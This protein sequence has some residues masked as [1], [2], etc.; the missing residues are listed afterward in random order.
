MSRH[1]CICTVVLSVLLSSL[2]LL[3]AGQYPGYQTVKDP[4][5][6][7]LSFGLAT[8]KVRSIESDFLQE[9]VLLALTE[10]I[11][12]KGKFWF[13][14]ESKVRMDYL[15]PFE[16]KMII[17]GDNV[18]FNDGQK[19]TQVNVRSNRL[20]Q[21]VNRIMI[22]C[23][24]GTILE[25]KEFDIRAFENGNSYL[26]E[27]KPLSG[28]FRKIFDMIILIIDKESASPEVIRMN[29]PSGDNTVITLTNKVVNGGLSDEIFAY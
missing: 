4:D 15:T 20:F 24:Q 29:E 2:P 12:S 11:T 27:L 1:R 14:R 16:Y 26:I 7:R 18:Y 10:R 3:V 22:E 13:K 28:A 17:N 9:K 6:F 8:S 19:E 21:Q 25:S 5:A 23:M